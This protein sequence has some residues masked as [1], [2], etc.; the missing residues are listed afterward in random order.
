MIDAFGLPP[1]LPIVSSFEQKCYQNEL[2]S[3]YLGLWLQL[4]CSLGEANLYP[5]GPNNI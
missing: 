4:G 5:N 3:T 2:F 1:I